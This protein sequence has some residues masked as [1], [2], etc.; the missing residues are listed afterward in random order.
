VTVDPLKESLAE[1]VMAVTR[2]RGA[3]VVCEAVGKP[4]LVNEALELARP[5]GTVLLVGVSPKESRLALSLWHLQYR[6]IRI[7]SVFGRGT[8]FRRALR[9]MPRLGVERLVGDRFPLERIDEAFARAAAGHGA[10]GPKNSSA[11]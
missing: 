2:G 8:A 10:S 5:T 9:L 11:S 4:E 7:A 1:R 3:E 6:Q